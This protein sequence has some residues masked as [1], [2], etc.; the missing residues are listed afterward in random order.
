MGRIETKRIRALLH[1]AT[2]TNA[3]VY[4]ASKA[5]LSPVRLVR[6]RSFMGQTQVLLLNTWEWRTIQEGDRVYA[7]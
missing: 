2:A 4:L 6:V 5:D 1:E 7:N 3:N